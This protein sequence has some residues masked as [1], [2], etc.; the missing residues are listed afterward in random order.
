MKNAVIL[1]SLILMG[2]STTPNRSPSLSA[3][4]LDLDK[5][6]VQL[7]SAIMAED[8]KEIERASKKIFDHPKPKD[9]LPKIVK[10]LGPKIK[11]F[12][13][14]DKQVH[15]SGKKIHRLVHDGDLK[16]ILIEYTKIIHNCVACHQAF[17]PQLK[18]VLNDI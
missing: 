13:R 9:D 6:L 11:Y 10:A 5:A 3:I 7:S 2:C 18:D 4:M 1:V 8:F 17:R 14:Y 16:P 15:D 12:K